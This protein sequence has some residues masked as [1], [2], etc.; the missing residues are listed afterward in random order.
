M[1][2]LK[3]VWPYSQKLMDLEEDEL[4]ELGIEFGDDC[5]YFV[6]LESMAKLKEKGY[7]PF[8]LD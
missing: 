6:P 4:N 7:W 3:V 1:S 8:E 5:S 2:Y